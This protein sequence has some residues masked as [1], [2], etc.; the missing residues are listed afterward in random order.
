MDI[1][2]TSRFLLVPEIYCDEALG[3]RKACISH[4][5]AAQTRWMGIISRISARGL[6]TSPPQFRRIIKPVLGIF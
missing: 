1:A 5:A 3:L 2:L 6:R 4:L